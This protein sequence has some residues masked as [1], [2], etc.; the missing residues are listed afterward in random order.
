MTETYIHKEDFILEDGSSISGLE[1]AYTILGELKPGR[2]IVWIFHALTATSDPRQ[3]WDGLVGDGKLFNEKD[4][5]II[6]VN[7][8]GSCYGSTGPLSV[9]P[10]T[11]QPYYHS[12]PVFSTKDVV[13]A[14]Q[15]VKDHLGIKQVHIGVGASMGGQHLLQWAV[16]EPGF[17]EN[18][19][20]IACNAKQSAW[21]LAIDAAQRLAIEADGTWIESHPEAGINGMKA[22]RAIAL[23]HYRTF[24]SF[25]DRNKSAEQN[26]ETYQ[27]YQ[28]NKLAE[29]FNAFSYYNLS[30]SRATYDLS[31]GYPGLEE[32]LKRITANTFVIGI[33]T[34]GL[35][36]VTEQQF[37]AEQI[38]D[39]KLSVIAS[40]YGHDGFLVEY[41]KISNLISE[42]LVSAKNS[43]S[44]LSVA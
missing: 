22:A 2:K 41:E 8:P 34:D 25:E 18:I 11:G 40:D 24:K 31:K 10:N 35:F 37:L 4:Y 6:G 33:E 14:F 42:F 26:A 44:Y 1:L 12:F 13:K 32:A 9:N 43:K 29:R 30:L 16:D 21:S 27:R 38:N 23:V 36:P 3:W 15:L 7:L 39:A 5:T 20:P 28:A 17:F 19:I